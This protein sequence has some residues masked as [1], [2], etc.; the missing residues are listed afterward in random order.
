MNK[1]YITS[2]ICFFGAKNYILLFQNHTMILHFDRHFLHP[3]L[4]NIVDKLLR[5]SSFGKTIQFC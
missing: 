4:S 5:K 1:K 2:A 3:C